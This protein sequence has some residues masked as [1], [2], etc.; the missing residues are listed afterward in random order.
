MT[1][2]KICGL[3]R[4][5][6]VEMVNRYLPDFCGFIIDFP[7]SH[8]NLTPDQVR[9]LVKYLRNEQVMPIGVFVNEKPEVVAELL[10]DGTI[11]AAQLHGNEDNAYIAKLRTLTDK[12]IIKAFPIKNEEIFLE[13]KQTAADF[14]LLDQGQGSG[15]TFDWSLL[16][17]EAAKDIIDCNN[18]NKRKWFLAGGLNQN[19][20]EK[21]IKLFHPYAVDLSSAVE[22]D[23][24]KDEEKV[25]NIIEIVRRCSN[26]KS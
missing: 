19:N 8:R 4:I 25:K 6:D 21:A 18:I 17:K 20:I 13:V 24:F 14:I 15:E 12:T 10:N 1:K 2:I 26:D 22:T 7:K 11:V 23:N 16:S 3:K 9:E 5:E